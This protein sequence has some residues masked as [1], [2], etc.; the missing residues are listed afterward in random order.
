MQAV[1]IGNERDLT[2]RTKWLLLGLLCLFCSFGVFNHSL[3]APNESR[4]GGMIADLYR[5]GNWLVLAMNGEP[6]LEKPPLLHWTSLLL[7]KVFGRVNEGLVRLPA[8]LYGLGALLVI[9]S[10]GRELGR[11]RA[12]VL[13]AFLCATS[14]LYSEYSR[15]VLTDVCVAFIVLLALHVFWLAYNAQHKKPFFYAIFLL[16][17]SCAFYAKGLIGP[18]LVM[19]AVTVFLFAR[20]EWKTAVL[21]AFLFPFFLIAVVAPWGVALYHEGGKEYVVRAFIDNQLG[22]FFALPRGEPVTSLPFVGRFLGFMADRPAPPDPYFAHKQPLYFYLSKLPLLTSP[23]ILLVIPT[24]MYWFR[25]RPGLASPFALFMRCAFTSMIVVLHFST[26]KV[27]CYAMPMLPILFL[28]IAVWCEDLS[29]T[30]RFGVWMSRMTSVVL[31]FI[32][33]CLPLVCLF[34]FLAPRAMYT[35]VA[36]WLGMAEIGDEYSLL[37]TPG[38]HVVWIGAVLCAI[39]LV[40]AIVAYGKIRACSRRGEHASAMLDAAVALMLVIMLVGSAIMPVWDFQRSY[41]P[42][43]GL[44]RSEIRQ[45]RRIALAL[46]TP[47]DVGALTF[48]VESRIAEVSKI[49]GVREF[50]QQGADP[51]GVIV[52]VDEL[53]VIEKSLE[54]ITYEL[55]GVTD[56]MGAKSKE[57]M[58]IVRG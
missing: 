46:D 38:N 35:R 40:I 18:G 9:V 34:A 20:K 45:N 52:H 49:P 54:G 57:F 8:A 4:E 33:V 25:R 30:D 48:Y 24:L 44:V 1:H 55:R 11:A 53:D 39:A 47:K 51:R 3:W 13:A 37:R 21:L 43:A 36:Q 29:P 16:L 27:A 12:G 32:L 5:S 22:R 17:A 42:I 7:C 31:P 28:M 2:P 15:I 26:A 56:E 10:W 41:E 14:A 23:W 50:L 6:F 58:L 19:T